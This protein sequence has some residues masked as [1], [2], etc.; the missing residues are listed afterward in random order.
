MSNFKGKNGNKYLTTLFT[1]GEEN[2]SINFHTL[3]SNWHWGDTGLLHSLLFIFSQSLV[4]KHCGQTK[5]ITDIC[6]EDPSVRWYYIGCPVTAYWESDAHLKRQR[7]DNE[8]D[9]RNLLSRIILEK[10]IQ[11]KYILYL[12]TSSFLEIVIYH[13]QTC[14]IKIYSRWL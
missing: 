11:R 14:T 12:W 5:K 2:G 3:Q 10:I 7:R 6:P 4:S 13:T 9:P 8:N 1:G